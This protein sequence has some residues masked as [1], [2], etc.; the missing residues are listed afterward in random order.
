MTIGKRITKYRK[1]QKLSQEALAEKLNITRQT[2]S[3]YENDI[4][5]PDIDNANKLA[6]TLN[7]SLDELLGNDLSYIEGKLINNEK[8][9]KNNRKL[10]RILLVTIYFIILIS[11]ILFTIYYLNKKDFTK[12]YQAEITC[13][14][15]EK[16]GST[17]YVLFFFDENIYDCPIDLNTEEC[18]KQIKSELKEH[19]II[20]KE[21]VT[22]SE[23]KPTS[24]GMIFGGSTTYD[25]FNTL[26]ALKNNL[27]ER[28]YKCK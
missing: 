24:Y 3:N 12:K 9:V 27:L 5:S 4:T 8:I 28:G 2:L 25:T 19:F 16:N 23:I 1:E 21:Y 18:V 14:I 6:K 17:R 10:L 26:N 20:V 22:D 11:G 7:I 15:K 13:Y